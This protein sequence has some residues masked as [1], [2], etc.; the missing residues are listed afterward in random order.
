[1]EAEVKGPARAGNF[2][3]EAGSRERAWVFVWTRHPEK[4]SARIL[5]A[6]LRPADC[7]LAAR[8]APGPLGGPKA[9][10]SVSVYVRP[11]LSPIVCERPGPAGGIRPS[12][13]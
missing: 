1:M 9:S 3:A 10:G 6:H 13:G 5:G 11:Q 2:P 4:R 12:Y 7:A 8:G